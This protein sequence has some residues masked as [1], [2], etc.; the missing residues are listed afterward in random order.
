MTRVKGGVATKRR[1]N[2][3]IKLAK[4]YRGTRGGQY[5]AS[6][7]AVIHALVYAYRDRRN[8]KRMFRRLWIARINAASRMRGLRYS[9]LMAGL[10]ASGCTLDRKVLAHLAMTEPL[11][12]DAIVE[13][14][15]GG[16]RA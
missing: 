6:R 2:K 14:A 9:E 10:K 1:H 7:E 3:W 12:F 5:K 15:R 16:L 8:R 4:G 11:A 13:T